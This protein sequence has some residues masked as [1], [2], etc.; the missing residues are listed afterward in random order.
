MRYREILDD[1][2]LYP[3]LWMKS[4]N[5][6]NKQNLY[7]LVCPHTWNSAVG[8]LEGEDALS[9]FSEAYSLW[10]SM[11]AALPWAYRSPYTL[12]FLCFDDGCTHTHIHSHACLLPQILRSITT[13]DLHT[14]S[15]T[16]THLPYPPTWINSPAAPENVLTMMSPAI[17]PLQRHKSTLVPWAQK[18]KRS[19]SLPP[20]SFCP[21]MV[22]PLQ[23]VHTQ[24]RENYIVYSTIRYS[25]VSAHWHSPCTTVTMMSF[26]YPSSLL[27][28]W[29]KLP[30]Q[31][32][33]CALTCLLWV[34]DWVHQ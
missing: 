6:D 16:H 5:M 17:P 1:V 31:A 30:W 22:I 28:T 26:L 25:W 20:L 15:H 14:Q 2:E 32:N 3:S 21:L 18:S 34:Y 11:T 33:L 9:T 8:L 7:S 4:R 24:W 23:N 27:V 13:P 10:E 19:L 12:A 29:K